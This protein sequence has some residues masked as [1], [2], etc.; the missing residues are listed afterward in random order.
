MLHLGWIPP[1]CLVT[2]HLCASG[3][4]QTQASLLP[5]HDYAWMDTKHKNILTLN[6][7]ETKQMTVFQPQEVT[8]LDQQ[9]LA[10]SLH[11][12]TTKKQSC[13]IKAVLFEE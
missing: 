9:F 11:L 6:D 8:N 12:T 7:A 3:T 4:Y 1:Y 2:T 5:V 10:K 13:Q